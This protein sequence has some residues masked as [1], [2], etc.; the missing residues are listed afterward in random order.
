LLWAIVVAKKD[1][2]MNTCSIISVCD[3]SLVYTFLN[4][5]SIT[6]HCEQGTLTYVC[7]FFVGD[8]FPIRPVG[9]YHETSNRVLK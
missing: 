3:N 7:P 4:S 1:I 6:A 8:W 2:F 9:L 5:C